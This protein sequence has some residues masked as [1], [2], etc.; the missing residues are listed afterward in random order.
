MELAHPLQLSASTLLEFRSV[1][2]GIFDHSS[3]SAFVRSGTDVGWE[4]LAHS[5]LSNSS[6]SR[7]I[8][9]RSGLCAGQSS[10]STPNQL[11]MSLWTLLW[12][13]NIPKLFPQSWEHEIVQHVLVCWKIR[14]SFHWNQGAK[15]NPWKTTPQGTLLLTCSWSGTIFI[16]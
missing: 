6:Q 5:L 3:W 7:S 16:F 11:I 9:S 14:S 8:R 1:F 12:N 10:S 15:P 4:G 2:M 13:R